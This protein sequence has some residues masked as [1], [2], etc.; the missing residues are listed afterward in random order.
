MG[1]GAAQEVVEGITEVAAELGRIEGR[2]QPRRG[3]IALKLT[4]RPD[5]RKMTADVSLTLSYCS[6]TPVP[7]LGFLFSYK[8]TD[9][10][11]TF[12]CTSSVWCHKSPYLYGFYQINFEFFGAVGE[13]GSLIKSGLL[14]CCSE[15]ETLKTLDTNC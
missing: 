9:I 7:S 12:D 13:K 2:A 11:E 14:S 1:G 6:F 15:K 3:E 5:P 8:V 4:I 10:F